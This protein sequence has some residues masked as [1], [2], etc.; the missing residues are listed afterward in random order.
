MYLGS[1][2]R[3]KFSGR[4]SIATSFFGKHLL[5]TYALIGKYVSRNSV[6]NKYFL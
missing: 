2:I 6:F 4:V 3:A 5:E 1:V